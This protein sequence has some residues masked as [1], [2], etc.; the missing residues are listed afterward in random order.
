MILFRPNH[1][2]RNQLIPSFSPPSPPFPPSPSI[3]TESLWAGVF[4]RRA[5]GG[6]GFGVKAKGLDRLI[7]QDSTCSSVHATVQPELMSLPGKKKKSISALQTYR[8]GASAEVWELAVAH[9]M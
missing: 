4:T 2:L 8:A 3:P 1:L 5:R 7:L 9:V 6:L